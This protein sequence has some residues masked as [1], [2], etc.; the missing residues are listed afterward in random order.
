MPTL[1]LCM[2]VRDEEAMLGGCL[3]SVRGFVDEMVV[4]DTGSRDGTKALALEAGARVF[5]FTWCDDFAAA[6]NESLRHAR[7]KWVLTLDADERLGP[8]SGARLRAALASAKFDCGMLRLHDACRVDARLEDIV[9]GRERQAE[10]QLV[11]RLLR[12]TDGLRY[13]DAIHENVAPWLRRRGMKVAGVEVDIVHLGATKEVVDAKSKTERNIRLLRTRVE[14]DPGDVSAYGY[15]VHD[16]MRSGRNEEAFEEAERGWQ[17]VARATRETL[18]TSI[19]R[20]AT[21]RAYLLVARGRFADARETTRH[22]RTL[23]GENPDFS[24]LEA[25]ASET[26]ALRTADPAARRELLRAARDGY[27]S[28]MRFANRVFAQSF[29]FGASTWSG[30]TRLGT[31]ELALGDAAGALRAF[32]IAL[33]ARPGDRAAQLGRAEAMIELGDPTGALTRLEALLDD[34][35]P[36][37]WTLA[38]IAV[39]RLGLAEDARLFTRRALSLAGKGFISAHRR[40]RLRE[41][42]ALLAG[43]ESK[44]R[45]EPSQ[46][47]RGQP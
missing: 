3:Q 38:A 34:Q 2:I 21:A 17:H 18:V 29:I 37:A 43:G 24:F 47:S 20:L 35:A 22:A 42:G 36:D 4:V 8:G 16:L 9:A 1:T 12:R 26:E 28:C 32:D 31:V 25:S 19:H 27:A 23:E 46:A 45:A 39:R 44:G 30:S 6:R 5:D 11:P 13:V 7:G 10:I 33:S 41:L 40:E 14:R 15:L